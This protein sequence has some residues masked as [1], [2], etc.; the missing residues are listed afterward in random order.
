MKRTAGAATCGSGQSPDTAREIFRPRL[1][2]A[3]GDLDRMKQE[4]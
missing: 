4:P 3:A 2:G 1:I